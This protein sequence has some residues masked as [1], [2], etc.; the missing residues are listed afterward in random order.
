MMPLLL[1]ACAL[2]SCEA[3]RGYEPPPRTV[4]QQPDAIISRFSPEVLG[5]VAV[6]S[7]N[8]SERELDVTLGMTK[9]AGMTSHAETAVQSELLRRG[10]KLAPRSEVQRLLSEVRIQRSGLTEGEA[11]RIGRRVNATQVLV[12]GLT[13][14]DDNSRYSTIDSVASVQLRL[15]EVETGNLVAAGTGTSRGNPVGQV[16]SEAANRAIRD[17]GL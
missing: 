4:S 14:C 1:A 2:C 10:V 15:I 6:I 13:N 5:T 8:E 11:A 16:V 7:V 3:P 17:A 12:V 9:Y